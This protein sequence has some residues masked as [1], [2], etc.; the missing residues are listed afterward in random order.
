[1]LFTVQN[2]GSLSIINDKNGNSLFYGGGEDGNTGTLTATGEG[3]SITVQ[4]SM[5]NF[6]GVK[7][8]NGATLRIGGMYDADATE[9]DVKEDNSHTPEW[10]HYANIYANYSSSNVG[11]AV[12]VS[13][14]TINLDHQ[15][16]FGADGTVSISDN[17]TINFN[18]DWHAIKNG[19]G[20]ATAII[21]ANKVDQSSVTISGSEVNNVKKTP[22]VNVLA[23]KHGAIFAPNINISDTQ[24]NVGAASMSALLHL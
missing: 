18:G 2:G 13:D 14:S 24:V 7:V 19:T 4:S 15:S 1:M 10:V 6:N 20:H 5:V 8:S 23:G 16:I 12:E 17:S 21:R 3:S 11:G 9:L 22:V